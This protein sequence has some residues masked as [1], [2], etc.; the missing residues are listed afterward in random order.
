MAARSEG[1]TSGR[2]V[3][4]S[5]GEHPGE[6]F[7]EQDDVLGRRFN[8]RLDL[9][10]A[11][12]QVLQCFRAERDAED[13]ARESSSPAMNIKTNPLPSSHSARAASVK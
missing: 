3:R 8:D 12:P 1:H 5:V 13:A 9:A 11:Q 2:C 7:A 6:D 10:I 4:P